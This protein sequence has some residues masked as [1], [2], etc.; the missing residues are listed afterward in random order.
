MSDYL[1]IQ[2]AAALVGVSESSLQKKCKAGEIPAIRV[3]KQYR[4]RR[5]DLEAWVTYVPMPKE[6]GGMAQPGDALAMFEAIDRWQG[7]MSL[8][9]LSPTT[10]ASYYACLISFLKQLEF[11]GAGVP[12]PSQLFRRET[13]VRGLEGFAA[14][15]H[16]HKRNV[17]NAII[18][19]GRFL[20]FE[21]KLQPDALQVIR[22]LRPTRGPAPRRTCLRVNDAPKLFH[23]ISIRTADPHENITLAAIVGVM[24]YC[25]LRVSEA[26]SLC[27]GDVSLQ[28][29][30]IAVRHGKGKKDRKV[31]VRRELVRL[32][33]N[34]LAVRPE[35]R[36]RQGELACRN[37]DRF[38][39][40]PDGITWNKD[41]IAWRMRQ[42]SKLLGYQIGAHSLRRAFATQAVAQG[43]SLRYVQQAL[44][45]C[46]IA[47][48]DAYVRTSEAE[49][50]EAMK[51]W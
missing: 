16:S 13:L 22:D 21:G 6:I 11:T 18:S 10:R 7:F 25:G 20:V 48:T 45:H 40:R 12:R 41:Q 42:L 29:R 30:S 51:E 28:E 38:F 1:S 9:E 34:Y 49:A 19:F 43:R 36:E 47:V 14:K 39:L 5:T 27:V 50:V 31:G 33:E 15:S 32:V 3:G 24:L 46:S 8:K 23:A 37:E 44:G 17:A 35:I 26:L 4:I 2:A